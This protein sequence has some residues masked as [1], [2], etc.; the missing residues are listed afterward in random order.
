MDLQFILRPT[1]SR[2]EEEVLLLW[3]NSPVVALLSHR[4]ATAHHVDQHLYVNISQSEC[5]RQ[6]LKS[7]PT[8][9]QLSKLVNSYFQ[10]CPVL[11]DGL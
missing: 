5:I 3:V 2:E 4:P 11:R 10:G 7:F 9:A 8:A 6:I 1:T